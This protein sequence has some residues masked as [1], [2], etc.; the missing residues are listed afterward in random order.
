MSIKDFKAHITKV[1]KV[2]KEYKSYLE[3]MKEEGTEWYIASKTVMEYLH[4]GD[5]L[6]G[7]DYTEINRLK[8]WYEE[9][10]SDR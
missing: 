1:N 2:T 3:V 9:D 7:K 4:P 10:K 8:S 6:T 5:K